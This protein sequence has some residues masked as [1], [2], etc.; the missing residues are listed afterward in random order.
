MA[1]FNKSDGSLRPAP[2]PVKK[3]RTAPKKLLAEFEQERA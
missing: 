1:N 2:E 3:K